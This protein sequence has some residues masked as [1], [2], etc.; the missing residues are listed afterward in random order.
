MPAFTAT[1]SPFRRNWSQ[2]LAAQARHFLGKGGCD[3]FVTVVASDRYEEI[4]P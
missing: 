4:R 2:L 1:P 3:D